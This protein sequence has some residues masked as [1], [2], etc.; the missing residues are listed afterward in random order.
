[1]KLESVSINSIITEM[2]KMLARLI[3]EDIDFQIILADKIAPVM[4]DP[5]QIEQVVMN[6]VVNAR[7]A[8]DVKD[9]SE[10]LRK[11]TIETSNTY[12]E[13]DK[14]EFL[15]DN[16]DNG[17][18]VMLSVSDT[19]IGMDDEL[20]SKI[21][22]PF[23]TTKGV[24]K[25]TGLGLST[26]YGIV[27]QNNGQINVY[28]EINQGSTIKIYWPCNEAELEQIDDTSQDSEVFTGN[29]KILFVEDDEAVREFAV[30]A[31]QDIG[32]T[33]FHAED[34]VKAIDLVKKDKINFDLLITDLVMPEINGKELADFLSVSIPDLKVI[35]TSG[36]TA[37]YL[38]GKDIINEN[39]KFLQKPYSL[40]DISHKIREVLDTKADK[41]ELKRT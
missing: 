9:K 24:G 11:I 17:L 36:Y 20:K 35:Y 15:Q 22:D 6:L 34:A 28:S 4:A 12:L 10:K 23:F 32:Y 5:G 19:G 21:F 41:A 1:V 14:I 30:A 18:Y 2:G 31:L 27:K 29:E 33:I 39:L 16:I 13:N 3:G 26:I 38:K 25:G 37:G 7:D 8:I 40:K